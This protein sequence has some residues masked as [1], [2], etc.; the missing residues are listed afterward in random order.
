MAKREA[1]DMRA[2]RSG[3]TV[4]TMVSQIDVFH[5]YV[6]AWLASAASESNCNFGIRTSPDISVCDIADLQKRCLSTIIDIT[7]LISKFIFL[8]I[9]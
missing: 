4:T 5:Y 1:T 7:N 8:I 2:Q 3:R 6:S 9:N